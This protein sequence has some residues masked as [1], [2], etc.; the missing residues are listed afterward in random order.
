MHPR[1]AAPRGSTRM[2]AFVIAAL[3]ALAALPLAVPTTNAC[4][5]I[6]E[7]PARSWDVDVFDRPDEPHAGPID[8]HWHECG[9]GRM[10]VCAHHAALDECVRLW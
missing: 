2:R 8:V 10:W 4:H 9:D 1:A 5:V 7:S 6:L 3:L